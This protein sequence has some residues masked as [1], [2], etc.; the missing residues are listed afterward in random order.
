MPSLSST[1]SVPANVM[2]RDLAGES[3]LLELES[4]QYFGLDEVGTRMWA[5]LEKHGA[6]G[7][8][9]RALLE[10]FEVQEAQ[11]ERD[12]L[13]F[14]ERLADHRLVDVGE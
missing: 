10:E 11:L 12:L 7:P 4:G 6:V 8:T 2:F 3:V 13:A 5:L 9:F 14:V 1:I